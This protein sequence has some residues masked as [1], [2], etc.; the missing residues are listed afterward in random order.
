VGEAVAA[1]EVDICCLFNEHQVAEALLGADGLIATA[2]PGTVLVNHTTVGLNVL[3]KVEQAAADC[4]VLLLDAPVSGAPDDIDDG[5]L[6]ILL[7]GDRAA[8]ER[9]LSSLQ[10]YGNIVPTGGVGSAS[11]VKLVNNLLYAVNA[12]RSSPGVARRTCART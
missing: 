1:G 10:A 7:G 2:A 11:R 6:T 8:A 9:A 3:A 5:Q 4:G 12:Q